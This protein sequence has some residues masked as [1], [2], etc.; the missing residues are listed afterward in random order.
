MAEIK[1]V[2]DNAKRIDPLSKTPPKSPYEARWTQ[3]RVRK[4]SLAYLRE[5]ATLN[6][7][8]IMG[9]EEPRS[10]NSMFEELLKAAPLVHHD[11]GPGF[12]HTPDAYCPCGPSWPK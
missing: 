4:S 6:P 3:M 8:I 9:E 7:M 5:L 1:P 2:I 10:M 11:M 12:T